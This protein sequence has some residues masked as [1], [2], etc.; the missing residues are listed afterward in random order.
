MTI[1]VSVVVPTC[2]RPELL[3]R[4]LAALVAQDYDPAAYEV[5]VAD[6]AFCTATEEIVGQMAARSAVR[7]RYL[8]VRGT[9][10]PAAARNV[11]WHAAEG[12]IIAFTDDDCV[13]DTGWLAGGTA[14]FFDGV[15]G[16]W[17]RVVVPQESRVTDYHRDAAKLER[18]EFVTA[19]CFYRREAL[20]A[21]GG[22]DE[23]FTTAW[24]EDSDLFF[25]LLER[26]GRLVHAPKA[27]VVHP[28]RLAQWGVSLWQQRKNMFNALLYKKH[29]HLYRQRIQA[30]PP[31]HYYAMLTAMLTMLAGTV[32]GSAP[33]AVTAGML[34]GLLTGW[35]C[36]RRL[37]GTT[38]APLHVT[39]MIATSVLIPPLAIYWRLV[40]AVRYRVFFL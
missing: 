29:P 11:G 10:G 7:M 23:R 19:N 30:A 18:A 35:F 13:P 32:S 1:R 20:A 36:Q 26:G 31:W 12:D 28:V 4:C 2:R 14:A 39:E 37:V 9:H 5:L 15:V 38:L 40:G 22:F 16:V 17:G 24:R 33:V 6:D 25:S 21:V 34:W 8:A 27:I 3:E